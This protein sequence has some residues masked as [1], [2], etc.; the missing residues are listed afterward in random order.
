MCVC[1]I[2][3]KHPTL[4]ILISL[5]DLDLFSISFPAWYRQVNCETLPSVS[6]ILSICNFYLNSVQYVDL[7]LSVYT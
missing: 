6:T 3:Y 2:K 7:D 1:V 4:F 5:T